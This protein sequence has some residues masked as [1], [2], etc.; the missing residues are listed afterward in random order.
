[1]SGSVTLN[2]YWGASQPRTG[3]LRGTVG[4]E[5]AIADSL[6]FRCR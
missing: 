1:M 2:N 5:A 4:G 6:K 3:T